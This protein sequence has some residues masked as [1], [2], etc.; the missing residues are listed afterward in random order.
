MTIYKKSYR[1][2]FRLLF[3]YLQDLLEKLVISFNRK[4]ESYRFESG[5]V[6]NILNTNFQKLY[7][8]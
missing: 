5:I 8:F 4:I 2:K 3:N 1:I 6:L 7:E